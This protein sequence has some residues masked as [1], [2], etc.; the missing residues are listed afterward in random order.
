MDLDLDRSGAKDDPVQEIGQEQALA[1][2]R[3]SVETLVWRPKPGIVAIVSVRAVG[4]HS[5]AV[6][7][8]MGALRTGSR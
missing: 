7:N 1:L 4:V 6:D 3:A 2:D 5:V 8:G